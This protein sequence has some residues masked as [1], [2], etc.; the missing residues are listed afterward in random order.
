V[1][2]Y[3]HAAFDDHPNAIRDGKSLGQRRKCAAQAVAIERLRSIRKPLLYP[4]SYEG[5][6]CSVP[7][8]PLTRLGIYRLV[9][10]VIVR[11]GGDAGRSHHPRLRHGAVR[12]VA[13]AGFA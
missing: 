3:R 10:C 13:R 7:T 1:S 5:A 11:A 9:V 6:A 4:L 2:G 12:P 8:Y